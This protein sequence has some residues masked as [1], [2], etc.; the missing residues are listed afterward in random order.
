[1]KKS[2]DPQNFYKWGDEKNPKI[3]DIPKKFGIWDLI[4]KKLGDLPKNFRNG[5]S[6]VFQF[7]LKKWGV[8]GQECR[9]M[10]KGTLWEKGRGGFFGP[11]RVLGD[12]GIFRD[13]WGFWDFGRIL[14]RIFCM[15]PSLGGGPHTPRGE[16]SKT[17]SCSPS[18]GIWG[19]GNFGKLGIWDFGILGDF[20]K[21]GFWDFWEFWIFGS[22][23][24]FGI[25]GIPLGAPPSSYVVYLFV[26][27]L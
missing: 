1:L 24:G 19:F 8:G 15:A 3:R 20:G 16:I 2:Q 6:Q 11:M 13:D 12:F 5:D 17:K 4:S 23:G 21:S 9:P 14:A 22:W 18:G 25:L 26:V 27:G 7:F 10:P